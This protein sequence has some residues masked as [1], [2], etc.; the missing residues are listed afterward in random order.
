MAAGAAPSDGVKLMYGI[1]RSSAAIAYSELAGSESQDESSICFDSSSHRSGSFDV[2]LAGSVEATLTTT[3]RS[4]PVCF[5]NSRRS[6]CSRFTASAADSFAKSRIAGPASRPIVS[7]QLMSVPGRMRASIAASSSRQASTTA[8]SNTWLSVRSRSTDSTSVP[9]RISCPPTTK[10]VQAAKSHAGELRQR[11]DQA[12][13]CRSA[14][15]A[16]R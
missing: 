11:A 6:P 7:P 15:F 14:A 5:W 8:A 13:G 2:S 10:L 12:D 9:S 16:G 3:T 4:T 1:P